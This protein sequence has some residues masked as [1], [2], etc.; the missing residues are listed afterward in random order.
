MHQ[1]EQIRYRY[2]LDGIDNDWSAISANNYASYGNLPSGNFVFR[3]K[4]MNSEGIWSKE[5]I[6]IFSI[7]PPWWKTWWAYSIYG[8]TSLLSLFAFIKLRERSS[9]L[10]QKKLQIKN[11]ELELLNEQLDEIIYSMTHD[12]RSPL[13]AAIG[14]A[15]FIQNNPK[16]YESSY[17]ML[18]TSLN[19]V[20]KLLQSIILYYQGKR[21]KLD[22]SVFSPYHVFN[23]I[24]DSVN[25]EG[26][27]QYQFD[28]KID[29]SIELK[30]DKLLFYLTI[31]QL[32]NKILYNIE[33][34]DENS[35]IITIILMNSSN[36]HHVT[37]LIEDNGKQLPENILNENKNIF[38]EGIFKSS[39]IDIAMIRESIHKLKG[40]IS[41][42]NINQK[43][44]KT[45]LTFE[46]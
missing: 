39:D 24:L 31:K 1:P 36:K 25:S 41:F 40:S 30:S 23:E 12:F 46:K 27:N 7:R 37:F 4:S 8:F 5:Q 17:P 19:K 29:P 26:Q 3:V 35:D 44:R 45:S 20:D 2:K 16:E 11:E 34:G 22:I 9:R 38:T 13:L 42:E 33:L 6:F 15:D 10:R 28:N 18:N 21:K 14:V 32:F 43:L